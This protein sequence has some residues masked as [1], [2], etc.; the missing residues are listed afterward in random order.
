MSK[1]SQRK[2]SAYQ[3][4]KEDAEKGFPALRRHDYLDCYM[5]GYNS[6]LLLEESRKIVQKQNAAAK[7]LKKAMQNG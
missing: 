5:N 4:G 7:K 1:T 6:V 3:M 2:R